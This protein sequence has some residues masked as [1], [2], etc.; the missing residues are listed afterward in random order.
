ME[1]E[2]VSSRLVSA[3]ATPD[4]KE[5]TVQPDYLLAELLKTLAMAK[6]FAIPHKVAYVK[7]DTKGPNANK[8]IPQDSLNVPKLIIQKNA[9]QENNAIPLSDVFVL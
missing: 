3:N 6:D 8:K 2:D 4:S 1:S 9:V 5:M 7:M